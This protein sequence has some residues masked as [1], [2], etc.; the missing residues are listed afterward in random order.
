[1]IFS[2]L[3]S[4]A[5]LKAIPWVLAGGCAL[6]L[7]FFKANGDR[8]KAELETMTLHYQTSEANHATTKQSFLSYREKATETI[9]NIQEGYETLDTQYKA[10]QGRV[11]ALEKLLSK[12]DLRYLAKRKPGLIKRR[13]NAGTVRMLLEL[14]AATT[15]TTGNN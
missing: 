12:H 5:G 3:F 14:E 10:A 9:T 1:M 6:G 8:L 7:W 2:N 15:G 11:G 4:M 13:V